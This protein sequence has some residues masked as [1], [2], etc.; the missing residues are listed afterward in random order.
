MITLE[1]ARVV[2]RA[3]GGAIVFDGMLSEFPADIIAQAAAYA[4]HKK[5]QD[6]SGGEGLEGASAMEAAKAAIEALKAGT[7]AKRGGGGPRAR[8]EE[9]FVL[10]RVVAKIKATIKTKKASMPDDAVLAAHAAKVVASPQHAAWIAALKAEYAAKQAGSD[11][12]LDL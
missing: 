7:W 10:S 6:A 4:I 11:L 9:S 12:D 3:K 2:A 8:D 1:D 5:A